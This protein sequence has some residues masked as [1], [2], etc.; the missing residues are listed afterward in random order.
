MTWEVDAAITVDKIEQNPQFLCS[1][2]ARKW[3]A[4]KLHTGIRLPI[5]NNG[6]SSTEIP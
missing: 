3:L 1:S 5:M 4:E 6:A 2:V